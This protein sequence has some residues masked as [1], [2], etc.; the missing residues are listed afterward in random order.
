MTTGGGE[1]RRVAIL[2]NDMNVAGGIQRVAANLV[3]DLSPRYDTMLL[4]VEPLNSPAFHEP[5]LDFR[6]LGHRRDVRSRLS[7]LYDFLVA[8]RTLRRFVAEN[9]IDTVLGIW[10]DWSSVMAFALPRSVRRIGTAAKPSSRR[11]LL[12]R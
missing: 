12:I 10:Y 9:R 3:R 6:S 1:R 11:M 5:G 2:I 7:L 4:S 8:G